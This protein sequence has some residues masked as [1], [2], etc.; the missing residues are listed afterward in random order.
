MSVAACQARCDKWEKCTG[1]VT[2]QSDSNGN[3]DCY[4]KA[5]IKLDQCDKGT[6]F[7]VYVKSEWVQAKGFNCYD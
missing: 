1:I 6:Y 2:S 7:D 4:R 3:V 5:D